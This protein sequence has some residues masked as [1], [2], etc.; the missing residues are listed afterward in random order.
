MES[1]IISLLP[2]IFRAINAAPQIQQAIQTS[3][4]TVAAVE[5]N[6]GTLLPLLM[7]IGKQMFPEIQD[8]LAAAAAAS[9]MFDPST[10]KWVQTA[11]N[12]LHIADPAL[13]VDGEYG[14]L[15]TAAVKTFQQ[16]NGLVA[17][18]WAGDATQGKLQQ[19]V[20]GH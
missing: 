10:V 18:G 6:A 13:D 1:L 11:L 12:V 19:A 15:T 3:T 7:Q 2:I 20:A 8:N 5:N 14:P 4:S 16:A 9:T 17:D